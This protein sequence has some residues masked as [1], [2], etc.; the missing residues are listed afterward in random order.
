[1]KKSK[2]ILKLFLTMLKIGLFTFGGGYAM[3]AI[4]ENE[5]CEKK[6]WIERKEFFDIIAI[7]ESTPGPIAINMS[8]Y[9]GYNVAGFWGALFATLGVSIPS[10]IIIYVISLFFDKFIALAYVAYAFKG[11]QICVIYLIISAGIKFIKDVDKNAFNITAIVI[12]SVLM[13]VLTI[14]SVN[15]SAVFYIFICGF[16]SVF[17]YLVKELK[18]KGKAEKK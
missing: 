3:I 6:K 8:T 15:F 4:L 7:S 16:L 18:K 14:F 12:I 5:F 1:M 2:T 9:V 11:I 17:I 13:T 10:F